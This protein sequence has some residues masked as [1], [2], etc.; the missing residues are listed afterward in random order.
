MVKIVFSMVMEGTLEKLEKLKSAL[1]G[2]DTFIYHCW[3]SIKISHDGQSRD[4]VLTHASQ[5]WKFPSN[6][7]DR[8]RFHTITWIFF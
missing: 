2:A 1:P 8:M 4:H 7:Q 6:Q 3:L 5:P